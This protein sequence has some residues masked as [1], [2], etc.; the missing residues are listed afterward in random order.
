MKEA[1]RVT[2]SALVACLLFFGF[3]AERSYPGDGRLTPE[4]VVSRH[5]QSIGSAELLARA[6]SR[7][8][9]GAT[10]VRFHQGSL[11]ELSGLG[12]FASE[13]RKLGMLFR[14][15][16]QDYRGEHFAFDGK[17]VT[18][19]RFLPGKI[20]ILAEF[21][22]R[23]DELMKQGLLGGALSLAWPLRN[24]EEIRRRLK[25]DEAKLG[26]R[27]VH[28][29][30]Y[31]AKGNLADFKILMFF[32]PETFRHIR[33]EY[34]LHISAAITGVF[35]IGTDKPDTYYVLSEEFA[36]FKEVDGL[37][38]P[39]RYTIGYS[40]EGQA[41]TFLAYWTIDAEQ[42]QHNGNIDPLMFTAGD[43]GSY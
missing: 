39:H 1:N 43:V 41:R 8:F 14:Y 16:G 32:E 24:P 5:L 19:G 38:L 3:Q 18:V 27:P 31:R 25:Y 26:G 33:T 29:L 42:W 22:N 17:H 11:G 20:S 35:A 34:R 2:T 23:F 4:T 28:A 37:T 9:I 30:E 36:N 6:Q 12:Q 10:K 15:D 13:G 21:V 7:V 40:S